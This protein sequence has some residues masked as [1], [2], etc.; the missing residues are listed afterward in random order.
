[1]ARLRTH[2]DN[3]LALI[4]LAIVALGS[5]VFLSAALGQLA[6]G[7]NS[8]TSLLFNHMVLGIGAG[9]VLLII[10]S[11]FPYR[12]YITAAPYLY[13]VSI[14]LTA[15]TLIPQISLATKGAQRWLILGPLSLQPAEF[16]KIGTI[17]LAAAYLTAHRSKLSSWK[18]GLGGLLAILLI[19]S[20]LLLKQPDT[21]TLIVIGATTVAM[22]IAA[23]MRWRHLGALLGI[24]ICTFAILAIFRPYIR[25]RMMTYLHP[26][27]DQQASG[28]QIK[29]SLIAIGSGGIF[30]RGLGQ[31]VQKFSYLPEP[32]SDSIF[33]VAGEEFGFV[34]SIVIIGLF[35][36]FALRGFW[37]AARAP[38]QFGALVAVGIVTYIAGEAL[39]NIGAMLGVLPLTG[40]PLIFISH[41]GSAMLVALGAAGVLLN[42][43]SAIRPTHK[44]AR[45]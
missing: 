34:G 28:Y 15:L 10:A 38:D 20:A 1:V 12:R 9:A 17:F 35:V 21:G 30:G 24:A 18:F 8:I 11:R 25:D 39:L 33:A 37:I 45:A 31:G 4:L 40:I 22:F 2:I 6:R 3:T 41:G 27:N 43:S 32:M 36:L 29:Q 5:V 19:P 14:F 16:L 23:G 44:A 42:I 26:S 13:G 7:T